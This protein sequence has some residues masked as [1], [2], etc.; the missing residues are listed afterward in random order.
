MDNINIKFTVDSDQLNKALKM[1]SIVSPQF[2]SQQERGFLFV[3]NG[4]TCSVYSKNSA[5]EAR[6]SFP[7]SDVE[8]SGSFM[9]PSDYIGVFE[10]I[11][12]PIM[13]TATSEGESFKVKY[14]FGTSGAVE[15]VSFD[16]RTM[17]SFES[18]IQEAMSQAPKEFNIKILQLAFGMTKPFMAKAS[19]NVNYEFY[20]TI[21]IFGDDGDPELA[22]KANGYVLTSNGTEACYFHSEAFL[23][24]GLAAASQHLSLLESFMS[25]SSGAI[26]I[27]KTARGTYAV[28]ANKDVVGW[29]HYEHSYKKF[30][31]YVKTDQV[32]VKVPSKDMYHQLKLMRAGVPKDKSRIRLNFDSSNGN[33]W[34]S[35]IDE[36]SA[37]TSLPVPPKEVVEAK[38][39]LAINVNV[40]HMLHLFENLKGEW[41]EFRVMHL[42]PNAQR[43]KDSYMLRTI[44]EFVVSGEGAVIGGSGA[45]NVLEGTYI[46][47]VTRFT[48]G[49]D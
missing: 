31:Y 25:Q 33:F 38:M 19:D 7:I 34:F 45:E 5:H 10:F 42:P 26:H 35:S 48:P 1:V 43:T 20:K 13:F 46:C 11:S 49:I 18:N 41:V 28:N 22:K 40:N 27:Y 9:Y 47:K 16:P 36:G 2:I 3:V 4:D 14:T 8:G 12:G 32:V 15:R 21:Q 37:I 30:S 17:I 6:S 23:N 44:D 24:K 29:P 39:G